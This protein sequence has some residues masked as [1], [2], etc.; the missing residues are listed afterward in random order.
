MFKEKL[1][2][3][4]LIDVIVNTKEKKWSAAEANGDKMKVKW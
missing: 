3:F 4:L 1:K 2:Y